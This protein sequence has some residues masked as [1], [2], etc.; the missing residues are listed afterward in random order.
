[1]ELPENL[2]NVLVISAIRVVLAI[3]VLIIGRLLA[4]M[5]T[6][7]LPRLLRRSNLDYTLKNIFI[8]LAYYS[9][10]V[11]VFLLA[12]GVLGLPMSS[13][14]AVL[15]AS[16][17]AIGIAM[18]DPIANLASGMLIIALR[19]F[20]VGDFVK[21]GDVSGYVTDLGFLSITLLTRQNKSVF[22]PSKKALEQGLTNSSK[23]ELMRLDLRYG[24]SYGDDILKAKR[25]LEEIVS[26]E[27]M[28]AKDPPPQVSVA[29]LGNSSV[30]FELWTYVNVDDEPNVIF[31]I[32][33]QVKLRFDA[34]G[35]TIPFPQRDVH[36]Y[37]E[38]S[39]VAEA[40]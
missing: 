37:Q 17:L 27:P 3:A 9:M 31:N 30:N 38:N 39:G 6:R 29:E 24:I 4:K 26:N 14:V 22:I 1:M 11:L 8:R 28:V 32:T 35:I 40:S 21:I 36:L 16:V 25:I 15:G 10:L 23:K 7:N 33:E 12:L 2:T 19:P 5:V 20:R 34:E 13:I 18:Q